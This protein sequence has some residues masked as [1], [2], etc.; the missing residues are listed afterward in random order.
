VGK[1]GEREVGDRDEE[2]KKDLEDES[3]RGGKR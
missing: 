2:K 1:E 3:K